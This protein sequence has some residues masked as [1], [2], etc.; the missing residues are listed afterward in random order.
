[1]GS[2]KTAVA[3]GGHYFAEAVQHEESSLSPTA[4]LVC[5]VLAFKADSNTGKITA[6]HSYIAKRAGLSRRAVIEQIHAIEGAGFLRRQVPDRWASAKNHEMTRYT[7]LI[8]AGFVS[9]R[10]ER[11]PV[12]LD[13]SGESHSPDLGNSGEPHSL[14]LVNEVPG[15]VNMSARSGEPDAHSTTSTNAGA[16]PLELR[17]P[18]ENLPSHPTAPTLAFHR[19]EVEDGDEKTPRLQTAR[20]PYT[21]ANDAPD[22]PCDG[23]GLGRSHR[24]HREEKSR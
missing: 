4:R 12:Y 15:L 22:A 5:L 8:P 7:L 10:A 18:S 9:E 24:N 20:H 19:V 6:S 3:R 1:M 13:R 2:R 23:C 14:G 11:G 21:P 17:P 16:A